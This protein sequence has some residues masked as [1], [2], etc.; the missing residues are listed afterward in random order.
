VKP[1]LEHLPVVLL[2]SGFLIFLLGPKYA[3]SQIPIE[4]RSKMAD[5]DWIGVEWITTGMSLMVVEAGWWV[6]RRFFQTRNP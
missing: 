4:T 3:I 1:V 6:I 5:F 2:I